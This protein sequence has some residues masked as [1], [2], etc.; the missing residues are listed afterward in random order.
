MRAIKKIPVFLLTMILCIGLM[1]MPAFAA[2]SSQ[3]GLEVTLTTDKESYSQSEQ[4]VATLTV[5]NTNDFAVS[6]VSLENVIP[7]GYTL[8]EGNEATK[9]VE[10]LEAGE[11]VS[12]TVTYV[13]EDTGEQPDT[14][15][16]TGDTDTPG[17]GDNGGST[18]QPGTGNDSGSGNGTSGSGSNNSSTSPTTGDDSNVALWFALFVLAGTGLVTSIALRKKSGKKMLSLFLCV[19]MVGTMIPLATVRTYAAGSQKSISL[20]QN[21]SVGFE[22]VILD[23]IVSY[24]MVDG[25][26]VDSDGDGLIDIDE[27]ALGTDPLN[28]DTDGDGLTDYEE[29]ILGTDPLTKN[30]YD[31][32]LDSD[33]DGLTDIDEV[34]TYGTDPYSNDTDSDGLSDYD[35]IYLY[36]TDPLNPDTDADTL[37]DGFEIEHELDPNK[38]RTDGI[39]NDGE[40][41]IEQTISDTGI[42]LTLKD[43]TNL[44]KPSISGAATGELSDNVFLATSTDSAFDDIRAVIGEA[45]Y[46]D[47]RDDYVDGLTLTFDLASYKGGLD[48]LVVVT[49]NEDGN[50]DVVESTLTGSV[51]SCQIPK[52]GTYCVLDLEEFLG[53]LGFDLSSYWDSYDVSAISTYSLES[54]DDIGENANAIIVDASEKTVD[55]SDEADNAFETEESDMNISEEAVEN[56]E[57][58]TDTSAIEESASVASYSV[59]SE[60][61]E[62]AAQINDELL[63][64]LNETNAALLSSTVSGQADIVFAIDTTGSMSSTINNVVTNVTSFATTLSENYNVKVNYALIDFK[65]LEE[66]GEG[67][68]V[69]VKNGSSN[70]FSDVNAF[71]DKVSTLIATGGGDSPECDV[72]ALETARRLNFRSSASKFIILI[73]DASYKVA[74][75]Y[76]IES[77][78]EEIELLKA[79]GIITSVVT[80]SSYKSTYQSLYESTGGIYANISS[81]TFSASLLSLA[82]MIGETTS[83]GTWVILKHG[84]RYVRLT[85]ETDQDGDGLSTTYELNSE[86]EIDL[87]LLIKAQLALHGVPYEEY[88]GKTTIT[89]YDAKSDPT[90]VD[91]DGDGIDDKKDTA[92][93]AKGLK[94][95]IIG[96]LYL[97]TCYGSTFSDGHSFFAY[98]SYVN[99]SIDFSGL[100]NGWHRT[101]TTKSWTY[102]NLTRDYTPTSEYAIYPSEYVC[103]GNGALGSGPSSGMG[104]GSSDGSSAGDANGVNYNMET[105]KFLGHGRP[106]GAGV[107][108]SYLSNTYITEEITNATLEKLIAYLSQ[109]SVNYWSL[110]HNCAKVAAEGWNYIS[111]TEV[112][113]YGLSGW[114]LFATPAALRDNLR[115]IDGHAED[116]QIS[117]AFE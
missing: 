16:D 80:S 19:A 67:T 110:E 81:S 90:K 51:L 62:Y 18:E 111:D 93:W 12:L 2:S 89:V 34:Q 91:T 71:V 38:D 22:T 14:G 43:E 21:I 55:G 24:D 78:D 116:W 56:A 30:E 108:C 6:N 1:A 98:Q 114:H 31:E 28:P 7:E 73:T 46:V 49:L 9:Q 82:D 76:G 13:P 103:I 107:A 57:E 64:E 112:S 105:A 8:A 59:I 92:P 75:D 11:T 17:R 101:D 47:G 37:S 4:I 25:E 104:D 97:V 35:E 106:T 54:D 88:V 70:W 61:E 69:V 113:A 84:Y 27:D 3:D 117:E 100:V 109:D 77:M 95:G 50:F 68:T 94:G 58:D 29:A 96:E 72:D 40:L 79:D 52:G 85:D 10:S 115:K 32:M 66:D 23:A 39:T 20:S 53:S 63:E 102:D 15:D 5:I 83:D 99:D 44:A 45:V 65:D 42:S 86:E 74:N 36:G 48:D 87:S 33:S 41:K 60:P 26:L